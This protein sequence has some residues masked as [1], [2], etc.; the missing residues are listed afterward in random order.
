MASGSNAAPIVVFGDDWGRNVSTLQHLFAVIA[1]DRLV[2][3]INSIGHRVPTLQGKDLRRAAEKLRSM[4]RSRSM[5]SGRPI[6]RLSGGTIVLEPKVIPWHQWE[7]ARAFNTW[8]LLRQCGAALRS[9]APGRRPILVTGSPPSA[10]VVGRLGE[11]A[12]IYFCMDDYAHLPNVSAGMLAPLEREMLAKVDCVV[13]TARRLSETKIPRSGRVHLLPQ[14]VN[15]DHFATRHPHPPELKTLPRPIIGFAGS[16]SDCCDLGLIA[17]LADSNAE[18]S[19]VLVGPVTTDVRRL[20]RPSVHLLGPRPY[21]RLPAYVQSFDVAIIP[22]ILNDW[23]RSVDPLKLLE[24]LAAGVPV[25]STAIPEAYKYREVI[26]IAE[27]SEQFLG[28]VR[29]ILMNGYNAR[30]QLARAVAKENTW[31]HR[32]DIFLRIMEELIAERCRAASGGLS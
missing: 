21:A 23:T 10:G 3:W 15:F 5:R 20:R 22:Y 17:S 12:S 24:Y 31:E 28:L 18:G 1:R 27:T 11:V 30:S 16:V 25:V 13:A 19:I 9:L 4:L 32:A 8:S 6:E 29:E 2:I 7:T 26:S 14:G